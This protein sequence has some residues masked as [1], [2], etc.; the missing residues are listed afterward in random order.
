MSRIPLKCK[1][2][3]IILSDVSPKIIGIV[4]LTLPQQAL[5]MTSCTLG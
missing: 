3:P 1:K 2:V 4:F 5:T